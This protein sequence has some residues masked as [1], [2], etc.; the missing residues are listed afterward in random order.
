MV[1]LELLAWC[2]FYCLFCL[3]VYLVYLGVL[4]V[5]CLVTLVG[6]SDGMWWLRLLFVCAFMFCV[7]LFGGVCCSIAV[8]CLFVF[9]VLGGLF[10]L[11]ACCLRFVCACVFGWFCL[12]CCLFMLLVWCFVFDHFNS[13]V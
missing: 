13:F 7:V 8:W 2:G 3:V 11:F 1:F 6:C 12:I 10:G 9:N 5:V 4:V